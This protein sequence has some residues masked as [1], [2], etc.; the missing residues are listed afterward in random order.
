MISTHS[1]KSSTSKAIRWNKKKKTGIKAERLP[2]KIKRKKIET[3]LLAIAFGFSIQERVKEKYCLLMAKSKNR[4]KLTAQ[5]A[6]IH[7]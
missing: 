7:N 6:E 1:Q 3:K 4:T 5:N 2:N